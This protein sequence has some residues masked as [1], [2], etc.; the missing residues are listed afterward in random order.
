MKAYFKRVVSIK[1][2][3]FVVSAVLISAADK[4]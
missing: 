1:K 3:G 4:H 2:I